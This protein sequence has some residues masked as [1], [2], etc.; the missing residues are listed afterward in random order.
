MNSSRRACTDHDT[1][2]K[3]VQKS[4]YRA[5]YD[6]KK[7]NKKRRALLFE[8]GGNTA[9]FKADVNASEVFEYFGKAHQF[10]SE[11]FHRNSIDDQGL[12]LIASVHFDD[13]PGP[14]GMDNAFW[15]GDEMA[16]GDGDGEV[17]GS[18]FTSSFRLH[19]IYTD[20]DYAGFTKNI[21]VIGHELTH[22]V[23]QHEADLEYEYQ[24]GALNE[25]LADVF[26][27]MIKQYFHPD[28]QQKSADAD[29]LVGEGIFNPSI[30]NAKALRSMKA[31][32]TAY[33]NPRIGKD[34]QPADMDGYRKLPNSSAG[35]WGGVHSNSGIPNR[36]F[37]LVA[38]GLGGFSWE[39]AGPIWYA[40]LRDPE[41]KVIDTKTAFTVFADLTTKYALELFDQEVQTVVKAAWVKVKVYRTAAD[42]TVADAIGNAP[43]DLI[44]ARSKS[45]GCHPRV[46]CEG[47]RSN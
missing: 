37:Y 39:K 19:C 13:I 1:A 28:G 7:S 9:A 34:R 18:E 4:I 5:I 23:I 45:Q 25:S 16:F 6:S 41:L 14:P 44:E 27:I 15:D 17:F 33:D 42:P 46:R 2:P 24:S 36:A 26:G 31:P 22:G 21:D 12:H 47:Y 8:E 30:T 29:W 43:L 32:G 35:D 20:C 10:F 38:T 11:V 3:V 40:A